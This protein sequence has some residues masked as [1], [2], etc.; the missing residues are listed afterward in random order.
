M[1]GGESAAMQPPKS[2]HQLAVL[3]KADTAF[4]HATDFFGEMGFAVK[5]ASNV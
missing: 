5:T 2:G 3:A 1:V 4:S